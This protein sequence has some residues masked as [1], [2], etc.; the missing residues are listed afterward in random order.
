MCPDGALCAVHPSGNVS[1]AA[2]AL[3]WVDLS[4]LRHGRNNATALE[5]RKQKWLVVVAAMNFFEI[6]KA[7]LRPLVRNDA[8][9]NEAW[10]PRASS[11]ASTIYI[12]ASQTLLQSRAIPLH[13]SDCVYS[14]KSRN[15]PRT[16]RCHEDMILE[17]VNQRMNT[18]TFLTMIADDDLLAGGTSLSSRI[19]P[20]SHFT[21]WNCPRDISPRWNRA[22][23]RAKSHKQTV[24]ARHISGEA[25]YFE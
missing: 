14:V 8:Q 19:C 17:S 22:C 20:R 6:G 11:H 7:L 13:R 2:E 21:C 24:G 5:Y 12:L 25:V 1:S 9:L 18:V 23:S 16:P 10:T 3:V 15:H 4:I